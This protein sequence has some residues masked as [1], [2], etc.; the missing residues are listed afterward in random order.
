MTLTR[1]EL[2]AAV[3]QEV[4]LSRNE[5]AQLV[6]L[7]LEE[8]ASTLVRGEYVK[9]STFGTFL[10]REK[11]ERIG[12]NPRTREEVPI[13][14]RRVLVFRASRALKERINQAKPRTAV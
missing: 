8:I 5:S 14:P 3:Y 13:S 11:A 7:V 1:K 12:R 10:V 2:T 6:E 4:G 9:V